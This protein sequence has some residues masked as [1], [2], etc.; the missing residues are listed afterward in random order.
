MAHS[1]ADRVGHRLNEL[2]VGEYPAQGIPFADHSPDVIRV[3][4][5][6][7][8]D[9]ELVDRTGN[10]WT[11]SAESILAALEG[12]ESSRDPSEVWQRIISHRPT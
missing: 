1:A 5:L 8:S 4:T 11:G 10:S 3:R 12:M 7:G 6:A 9:L 2:G